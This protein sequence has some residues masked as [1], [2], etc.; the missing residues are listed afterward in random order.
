[1]EWIIIDDGSSDQTFE[2]IGPW[3]EGETSFE[4]IYLRVKNGGKHRAINKASDLARGD[5]FFIVDSDDYLTEDAIEKII[6]WE[7][8]IQGKVGYAGIAGN[9]GFSEESLIGKTFEGE[10]IDATSLEREKYQIDGDKAEVFY[11]S[12]LKKYKFSFKNTLL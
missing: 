7:Q 1:M 10:Y 3:I 4:I 2:L 6:K 5:L 12:I 11:T 9:K 8:T